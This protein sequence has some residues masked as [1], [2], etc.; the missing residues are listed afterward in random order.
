MSLSH[1]PNIITDSLI[2]YID[3]ASNRSY[4]NT[5]SWKDLCKTYNVTLSNGPQRVNNYISFD[6]INQ[7]GTTSF[8]VGPSMNRTYEIL[9]R[10]NT[11]P[12]G[13]YGSNNHICGGEVGNN[14]SLNAYPISGSTRIGVVYDDSRY[15]A[16]HASNKSINSGEW[17]HFVWI[18]NSGNLLKYYINGVLDKPQFTS[19]DAT[20]NTNTWR[21]AY[22]NRWLTY[23]QLDLSFFRVYDKVLSDYEIYANFEATRGRFGL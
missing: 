22:D 13:E 3:A 23:S 10:L 9:F 4:D 15:S 17:V 14:I 19:V 6:G 18:S 8:I 16:I 7:I 12:T 2:F 20:A 5:S 21:F 11:L 1:S